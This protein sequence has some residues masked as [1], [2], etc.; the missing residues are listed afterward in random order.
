LE[1]S[2]KRL[3]EDC[4]R[5]SF[6]IKTDKGVEYDGNLQLGDIRKIIIVIIIVVVI[7][8]VFLFCRDAERRI[9]A[10]DIERAS[11][12]SIVIAAREHFDIYRIAVFDI[13]VCS[14]PIAVDVQ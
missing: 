11:D 3:Q 9:K 7:V 13:S 12:G 14:G 1:L 2:Q 4:S 6:W 8:R 5:T 10:A